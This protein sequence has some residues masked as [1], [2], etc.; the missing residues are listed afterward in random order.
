MSLE[1]LLIGLLYIILYAILLCIVVY[2]LLYVA[3]LFG[4]A[5]PHPIPRLIWGAV[6]IIILILIVSLLFGWRPGMPFRVRSE[7]VTSGAIVS[8]SARPATDLQEWL[9]T[10]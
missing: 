6:G 7:P 2:A 10:R 3:S 9:L 5:L 4:I 1:G 8:V